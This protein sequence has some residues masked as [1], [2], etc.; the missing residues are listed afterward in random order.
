[1]KCKTTKNR[2]R[3]L[4]VIA[5][6]CLLSTAAKAQPGFIGSIDA[7]E[8]KTSLGPSTLKTTKFADNNTKRIEAFRIA[9]IAFEL[10]Y[11]R[12]ISRSIEVTAGYRFANMRTHTAN[13]RIT[14]VTGSNGSFSQQER[15]FLAAP[16]VASHGIVLQSKFYRKGSL[17]PI[18]KFIGI[19]MSFQTAAVKTG[20]EFYYGQLGGEI[21]DNFFKSTRS[22]EGIDT[23]VLDRTSRVNSVHINGIIGRNF[24][25]T[26]NLILSFTTRVHVFSFYNTRAG[27]Q[28]G[29]RVIGGDVNSERADNLLAF[30]LKKYNRLNFEIGIKYH[31]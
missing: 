22:I 2:M 11:S 20:D 26:D 14:V 23:L 27:T 19:N 7:I 31:L 24:P 13:S 30:S 12:T 9:H 28:W 16:Q 1:M 21:Q 5:V 15:S 25:I 8:F 4:I 17:A 10:N 6:V 18:G 3:E 29:L